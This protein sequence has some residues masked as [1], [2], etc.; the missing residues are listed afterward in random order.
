[1]AK[2]SHQQIVEEVA[3]KNFELVD[4]SDYKNLQSIITVK[5]KEKGH[6]IQT[7]LD[8]IRKPSFI[9][10]CCDNQSNFINPKSVPA[11]EN[12]YRVIAFDQATEKFGLSIFDDGKLV[13]YQLYT[14][15][16][17]LVKRLVKI[18]QL[19]NDVIIKCWCPDYIVCEDIQ[20]QNGIITFKVLAQLLGIVEEVAAENNIPYE[21][22]SPNV[23]RKYAG[24]CGK[25][26]H[27]EK[28]L[29]MAVVKEKYN[30]T[31]NDDVAEAILIG[32]YGA[33]MHKKEVKI[34]FGN[35]R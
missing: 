30:I 25:T 13:F 12:K 33:R 22:V 14:F 19:I 26:R 27:E 4:D 1:M 31:V 35:K 6:T 2:I 21:V 24:T 7:T 34:A 17:D 11:K 3:A 18:R 23:W 20:Y 8:K 9:C 5:C 32:H 28:M 29:S 16:G 10:P 15:T